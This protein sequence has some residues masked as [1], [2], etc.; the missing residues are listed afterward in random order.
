[1]IDLL[2]LGIFVWNGW[3]TA[4][5]QKRA[6]GVAVLWAQDGVRL[7]PWVMEAPPIPFRLIQMGALPVSWVESAVWPKAHWQT[8]AKLLQW[9]WALSHL[10]LAGSFW[11]RMASFRP[12]AMG[13]MQRFIFLRLAG[14]SILLSPALGELALFGQCLSWLFL[15][16]VAGR[17]WL[18]F[19]A[20]RMAISWGQ[21]EQQS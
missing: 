7:D 9:P 3:Q 10:L 1:M 13:W 18:R 14:F 15:G 19:A 17:E 4:Q 12:A 20:R 21:Q 16:I 11:W 5:Q 6:G 8:P 2:L